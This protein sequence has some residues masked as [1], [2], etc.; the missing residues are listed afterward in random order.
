MS[1]QADAPDTNAKRQRRYHHPKFTVEQVCE[2][3]RQCRGN[4]AAAAR[5]LKVERKTICRYLDRSATLRAVV[6]EERETFVDAAED[7][8]AALVRNP[9]AQGHTAACIFVAK[10]IGK[11]RGWVESA[12][13]REPPPFS[14]I[15]VVVEARRRAL[16]ARDAA[17]ALAA[18]QMINVTPTPPEDTGTTPPQQ[19]S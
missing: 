7:G 19:A 12:T 6:K 13:V 2:A 9:K 5:A 14:I 16:A 3:L 1:N 11:A 8:L 10:T 15:D 17:R 4:I 18:G